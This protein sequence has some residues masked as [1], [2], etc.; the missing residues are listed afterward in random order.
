MALLPVREVFERLLSDVEP[1]PGEDVPLDRGHDR[2]L[3]EPLHARRTQPPFDASAMDGYAVR[4]D[5]TN[6][7]AKPLTVIGESAA[8]RRFDGKLEAGQAVRILT[9]APVP[10]GADSVLIQ[11]N[12]ERLDG[13]HIRATTPV[14]SG[15]NIRKMGLDFAEGDLL[16]PAGRL[17][18]AG[19]LSLAAAAN[20]PVLQLV[21]RPRIA[22]IA[23]GDELVLPGGTP[24]P[25]QIIASNSYGVAAIARQA[26]AEII[27]LGVVGDDRDKI[28][29]VINEARES[30]DIIVTLGGA[31]V[32]DHDLVRPVLEAAGMQ[33]D[34][35]KVAMRPGKPLMFGRLGDKRVLGLP[36]NPVASL[37]CSHLFLAPLVAALGGR[38]HRFDIRNATL[39][40]ALK[41]NDQRQDY[42]R[43]TSEQHVERL[44]VTPFPVQDSSMLNTLARADCLIIRPPF[45]P[46]AEAGDLV[47]VM[48]IR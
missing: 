35:W 20:H 17:L 24:G 23:T 15:K 2:V 43:A 48:M 9:G 32:G 46:A 47:Q 12:A 29:A 36:G 41:E 13:N 3:A 4:A 19:A 22:I 5:D 42:I 18:D 11:E 21:R 14:A 10:G 27:D 33:L 7:P 45:A 34:F 40:A 30:A 1:L 25:D 37:I 26:G 44:T 39:T 16:L 6:D 31:S 8:G 28:A 38:P